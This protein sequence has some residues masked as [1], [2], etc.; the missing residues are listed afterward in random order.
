MTL[1]ELKVFLQARVVAPLW[2]Q[3]VLVVG[4][5]DGAH[6]ALGARRAQDRG[7]G[8]RA[9]RQVDLRCPAHL[10]RSAQG[11]HGE[12]AVR[13]IEEHVGARSPELDQLRVHRG[14]SHFIRC[15]GHDEALGTLAQC[16]FQP[17][18][19]VAPEIVVLAQHRY[20]RVFHLGQHVFGVH[21]CLG[22][23]REHA[24]H[25]PGEAFGVIPAVGAR[26][27]QQLRNTPL[28]EVA[29]DRQVGG[30]AHGVEDQQHFVAFDEAA[31]LLQ[32][33]GGRVAVIQ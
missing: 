31:R 2:V 28:V 29:V 9:H 11:L 24:A 27:D 26:H 13:K 32:R 4:N 10:A 30:R 33:F 17:L 3:R 18:D 15:L 14:V 6:G 21:A 8:R 5:G 12:F 16:A 23:V 25:G 22:L 20:L 7:D 1:H 19:E